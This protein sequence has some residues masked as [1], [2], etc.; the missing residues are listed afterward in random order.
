MGLIDSFSVAEDHRK[1]ILS[2]LSSI[3]V[4]SGE[5]H[6][7]FWIKIQAK[8][9]HDAV[10]E[11]RSNADFA[12]DHMVDL[13]GVDYL[14]RTPRFESVVHLY[15][16]SKKHRIRLRCLVG[17][18]MKVPSL[19]SFWQAANWQERES[20]DM[21]GIVYEGHPNLD[22]ILSPPETS[23]YPQRK[24]YALKGERDVSEDEL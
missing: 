16:F 20:F 12:F 19:T 10:K 21:Y 13:C 22:R 2:Q 6:G 24:D 15:S 1:K 5:H 17:E 9:L 11:L 4:E 3:V 18:D 8:D 23:V 14:P 7:D